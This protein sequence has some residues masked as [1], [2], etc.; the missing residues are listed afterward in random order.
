VGGKAISSAGRATASEPRKGSQFERAIQVLERGIAEHAFPGAVF[1]ITVRGEIL[2]T[3]S[4]GRLTYDQ[5]S[6]EVRPETVFDLASLTKVLATTAMAMKLYEAQRLT[7]DQKIAEIVPEF[8]AGGPGA[9]VRRSQITLRMLLAHSS[10]L[11][12]YVRLFEGA[13]SR[14]EL[15]SAAY[16]VPLEADPDTRAEYSD[17]GFIILGEALSRISGQAL[18]VF[19]KREIFEPLGMEYTTYLPPK[20]WREEI[21]PTLDDKDFRRRVIQGEVHDENASVMGGIA[22]HAG[23]FSSVEDVSKFALSM[24]GFAPK[25]F[26]QETIRLFTQQQTIPAGTSRA[27]GWDTPSSPSQSGKHFSPHSF[28]HLGYTGTS[29]WIDAE[30]KISI[31][32]LTNRSWPDARNQVIK[33][34]RP[35]F[36]DAVMEELLKQS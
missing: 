29:L 9:N 5:H 34:V 3:D 35:A 11:P 13:A 1:A 10:G 24:L 26:R 21:P 12:A 25:L 27:L 20:E 18:N 4:L 22:G 8:L 16:C 28:G 15:L 30:R 33:Q 6:P 32:L 36:Y 7:L 2:A 14:E 23:V 17:I 19:C 31:A